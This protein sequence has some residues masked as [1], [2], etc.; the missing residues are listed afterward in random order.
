MYSSSLRRLSLLATWLAAAAGGVVAARGADPGMA[1]ARKLHD[2]IVYRDDKF[3]AS[4]PSVVR[5][6]DGEILVAFRRAPSRIALGERRQGHVDPNSYLVAVRSR[7]AGNTWTGSPELIYAHAFGGSQDPC[8]LQ[9][10]DSTLLC[11]SY[12][13]AFMEPEAVAKLKEPYLQNRPGVVFLG[14]YL[15]RSSDGGRHWDGPIY[16]P[17][18]PPE[19]NRGPY[20]DVVPA[21]NRGGLCEG[22]DGR[23]FWVVAATD[24]VTPRKNS[25]HLIVSDD[26]GATWRYSAP[27]AVDDKVIFNETSIYETPKGDLVAFLRTSNFGGQACTARSTDGGKTFQPW[28]GMGFNGHPL[29]A[30]RLP[31]NRVLLVYGYREKP[32]GIRARILDA[33][34]TN[35]GSAGEIIL[36]DDGGSSDIGYPWAAPLDGNRVLVVY[37]F[38][39]KNGP[40]HIAGTILEIP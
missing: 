27:V 32:F 18:I 11:A 30:L 8:L 36:R 15:V 5:R 22:K 35:A 10:R 21:Y 37:Y 14:G 29:Q 24:S 4:F 12:G 28:Q 26:K 3:Y 23:L 25:T 2:V 39:L 33:E 16:P 17:A 31:D 9:L 1:A 7:D 6:P 13:W 40:R 34:C 20:G 19:L 38:N